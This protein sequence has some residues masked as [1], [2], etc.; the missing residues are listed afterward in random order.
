MT[1]ETP[2]RLNC[3]PGEHQFIKP[4]NNLMNLSQILLTGNNEI[5][6][7]CQFL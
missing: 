7:L 2:P 6:F 5:D 4:K 3:R 1:G